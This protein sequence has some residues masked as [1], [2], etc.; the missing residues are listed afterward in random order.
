M[1]KESH[2]RRRRLTHATLA[3]GHPRVHA[4]AL[5]LLRHLPPKILGNAGFT[6]SLSHH[7][8]LLHLHL[9]AL[10]GHL[11]MVDACQ[12][13]LVGLELTPLILRHPRLP[14][15]VQVGQHGLLHREPLHILLAVLSPSPGPLGWLKLSALLSTLLLNVHAVHGLKSL[16]VPLHQLPPLLR[17]PVP[18][19][20]RRLHPLWAAGA[21]TPLVLLPNGRPAHALHPVLLVNSRLQRLLQCASPGPRWHGLRHGVLPSTGSPRGGLGHRIEARRG[22]QPAD[23]WGTTVAPLALA[24]G[25]RPLLEVASQ[26]LLHLAL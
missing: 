20:L 2:T 18:H 17:Q 6:H 1:I 22:A 26:Q 16:R 3:S 4:I 5:R 23:A 13:R 8:L 21:A 25:W 19:G 24:A 11:L 10:L 12:P 7:H 14:Q 15:R 9:L